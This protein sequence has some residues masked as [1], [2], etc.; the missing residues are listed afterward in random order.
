[1]L[2]KSGLPSTTLAWVIVFMPLITVAFQF[3]N[4]GIHHFCLMIVG[5]NKKGFQATFRVTAYSTTAGLWVLIPGIGFYLSIVWDFIIGVAGLSLSHGITRGRAFWA[6]ALPYLFILL[7]II[8][9]AFLVAGRV[10]GGMN[11]YQ[12]LL[13]QFQ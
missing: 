11:E 2:G 3:I 9:V 5:G 13:R 4:A 10:M 6:W 12:E 8:V 7:V 1:M